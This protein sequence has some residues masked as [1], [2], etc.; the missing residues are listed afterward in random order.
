MAGDETSVNL[1]FAEQPVLELTAVA[2]GLDIEPVPSGENPRIE[3]LGRAAGALPLDVKQADGVVKVVIGAPDL[4]WF[5]YWGR[6]RPGRFRVLVPPHVR[7]RV[8]SDMGM[9]R[10]QG[11]EGCDLAL[12]TGAGMIQ[13]RNVRG[14]LALKVD[15]GQVRGDRLGGT[16]NVESSMGEV[17]LRID[18]LDAGEHRIHS[19]MGSVRVALASGIKVRI[20]AKTS[21]GSTRNRFP[22]VSDADAILRLEADLGSVRVDEAR[23]HEDE[24]VGDWADWRRDWAREDRADDRDW[25]WRKYW[26]GQWATPPR[27]TPTQQTDAPTS[28]PAAGASEDELKRIL[29]MVH[30]HKISAE[31]AERLIRAMEG[32]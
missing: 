21:M 28:R 17:R 22:S 32:R 5:A 14:R 23:A 12:Q 8:R 18:S 16:F 6:G 9:I 15:A 20:E 24:R 25:Q 19:N 10:A 2:A 7:A 26:W 4:G 31:E 30:E 3:Y 27:P 13:L 11:L 29:T 1:P